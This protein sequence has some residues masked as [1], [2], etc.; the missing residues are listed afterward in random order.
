MRCAG[1]LS[2]ERSHVASVCVVEEDLT[3]C[4]QSGMPLKYPGWMPS[5]CKRVG[6]VRS[7][8][9]ALSTWCKGFS[10]HREIDG[11]TTWKRVGWSTSSEVSP[12]APFGAP[13]AGIAKRYGLC[14][15]SR[16]SR[17]RFPLPA[18]SAGGIGLPRPRHSTFG[19]RTALPTHLD[20][21]A[22]EGA[23]SRLF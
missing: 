1:R 16:H 11:G 14:L 12:G 20:C 19:K 22:I 21:P 23:N 18:P 6:W 15:P 10:I 3:L 5:P 4:E 9:A 7:P 17:V 13:L 8:C 2:S